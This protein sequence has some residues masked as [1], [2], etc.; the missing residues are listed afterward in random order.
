[1]NARN[2]GAAKKRIGIVG[3]GN[4]GASILRGLLAAAEPGAAEEGAR[5]FLSDVDKERLGFFSS[6]R[7]VVCESNAEV[8][9]KSEV[10]ILAVKPNDVRKVVEEISPFLSGG[11]KVLISVAAGVPTSAVE[12]W[13]AEA[14]VGEGVEAEA[15]VGVEAEA[16]VEAGVE[17]REG[18]RVKVV[19]VMPNVGARVREAVSAVCRGKYATEEDEEL[20]KWIF[21]AVGTVHSVKESELD[22]VTG[23]SGSGIA[24]FA[25]VLDAVAA[26]GVHEGL[27]YELSL[28]IAAETAVGAARLVLAGEKPSAIKE[29]TA[30][31]G[32][33]TVRGLYALESRAVKAAMMMAVIAATRRAREIAEQKNRQIK[34]QNSK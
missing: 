1:M 7:V 4:I 17:G 34:N 12:N 3:V 25:E 30:S 27:P 23:L 24:F 13:F 15:G 10:V 26:G 32:G 14:G 9:E 16:G 8:A 2:S 5:I 11:Q 20:A 21:S 6:S 29:M 28:A 31:P 18:A 19:R 22:V 33:T